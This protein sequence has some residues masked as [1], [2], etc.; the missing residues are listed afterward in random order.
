MLLKKMIPVFALLVLATRGQLNAQTCPDKIYAVGPS[1]TPGPGQHRLYVIDPATFATTSTYNWGTVFN[2]S[3]TI[4]VPGD[5][6]AYAVSSVSPA[7]T[8]DRTVYK[9][10]L[11]T[12]AVSSTGWVLPNLP[13]G[14]YYISGAADKE[15]NIYFSTTLGYQLVKVN[16]ATG[17]VSTVWSGTSSAPPV[18]TAVAAPGNIP[19]IFNTISS[20]KDLVIDAIGDYYFFDEGGKRLWMVPKGTTTA[21]YLGTITGTGGNTTSDLFFSN[22]SLYLEGVNQLFKVDMTTLVATSV[23]NTPTIN[24]AAGDICDLISLAPVNGNVLNDNNG[25]TGGVDGTPVAGAT[26]TLY[27]SNGTTVIAT[28][29]TDAN[30]NYVFKFT[31]A[32]GLIPDGN[33][34]VAV[35]PPAGFNN[36]S[37]TDG[38]TPTDGRTNIAIAGI[39]PVNTSFG[40]NQPPVTQ[41]DAITATPTGAT[42]ANVLANDTD[43]NGGTLDPANI[44]LVVPAGMTGT[45]ITT[46]ANGDITSIT[47]P[48]QGTWTLNSDGSLTFT[49]VPGYTGTPTPI[50]YTVRDAAGLTSLPTDIT[51]TALPVNFGAISATLKNNTLNVSWSTIWEK[52]CKDY[53][54]EG[55]TDGKT[56]IKLGTVAS[57]A[58]GGNSDTPLDYEFTVAAAGYAAAGMGLL[59]ALLMVPA[60]RNRK[61]QWALAIVC[62]LGIAACSKNVA[63]EI[64]TDANIGFVRIVQ[65]DID[66]TTHTTKA[67]KVVKQ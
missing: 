31:N 18:T 25:Q 53:V 65:Y 57:K 59:F 38:V 1:G 49:K 56:W 39:N 47:V 42:V 3:H 64:G 15:G 12:G 45:T 27:A 32:G 28:T 23:A 9:M 34:V 60:F 6:F 50:Q 16:I 10:D 29:T 48:N 11:S 33:Y 17:T 40:V 41:P 61:L 36:V 35:T 24:D 26:V 54:I 14:E 37:S 52:S 7:T 19:F 66:G 22:G 43:P 55:S 58:N 21:Y 8:A 62:I 30:G 46:D 13:S 5:G 2:F 4:A 51:T 63:D 67:I 44:S 20:S